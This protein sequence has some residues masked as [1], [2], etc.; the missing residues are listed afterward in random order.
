[1]T[2]EKQQEDTFHFEYSIRDSQDV[3]VYKRQ[4]YE[5]P[6]CRLACVRLDDGK[7]FYSEENAQ[8]V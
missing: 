7:I 5:E 3:D 2:P 8:L 6:G 4:A 1:M